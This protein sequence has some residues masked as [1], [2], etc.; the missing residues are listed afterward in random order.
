MLI[1]IFVRANRE[2]NFDLYVDVLEEL[3]PLFFALDHHH[4]ARYI[5]VHI[6]DMKTLPEPVL[7]Q[8]K[9]GNFV[10]NKSKK[11]FSSI[12]YDQAHEQQN[13]FVKG[14]G[15]IIGIVC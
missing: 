9:K 3:V 5:P 10:A 1:L 2:R 6:F 13:K 14:S 7:L 11:Y 8:F 12:P 4:Y 15:G